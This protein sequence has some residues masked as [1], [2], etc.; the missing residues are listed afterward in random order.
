MVMKNINYSYR[1]TARL[2]QIIKVFLRH[3]FGGIIDK[4]KLSEYISILSKI[5]LFKQ[6]I[7]DKKL[8]LPERIRL[9]FEELGPTFV[10]LGQLLST[11]PDYVPAEYIQEF[12]KLQD[13]V[14]PFHHGEIEKIIKKEYGADVTTDKLFKSFNFKPI[15]AASIAQVHIATLHT[16]EEVAIKMQR[17]NIEKIIKQ[18]IRI[19]YKL[20]SI[21][22]NNLEE[23]KLFDPMGLVNEFEKTILK[24]LDFIAE[25]SSIDKF[26]ENF[27]N[28]KDIYIPKVYWDYTTHN[29]LVIERIHGIELDEIV[30]I[31]E[32]GHNP[33][34]VASI[35]LNCFCKQIME[36]GFFHADPHPGNSMVMADGRVALIDY[37]IT[38]YLDKDMMECLANIFIGYAEHDYDKLIETFFAMDILTDDKYLPLFKQ[39]LK[40]TSEPFYGRSL[41]HI[42]MREVFDKIIQICIKHNI[43]LPRNL[44]LLFKTFLQIESLGRK[45]D[46]E[47]SVLE[48]AKPYAKRLLEKGQDH[49]TILKKL[50]K[51]VTEMYSLIKIIPDNVNKVLVKLID[52][53]QRIELMHLGLDNIDTDLVRGINRITVGMIISASL[54]GSAWVI[55]AR[56]DILLINIVGIGKVSLTTL[57]GICGYNIATILGIW[58]VFSIIRSGKL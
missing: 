54:M 51:E 45:L 36:D 43:K 28:F 26:R 14:P 48:T 34:K 33:K 9:A 53:K 44:L 4:L 22:E 42:N 46:P 31:Q 5:E 52:G 56:S 30:K 47:V 50:K 10:K 16:G 17:P 2:R 38:G 32:A 55:S 19:L 41:K 7:D 1:N 6:D 21:L 27:K 11:R 35:G 23:S 57:L 18:D 24:E 15:A 3:G 20:A 49:H 39:D 25:A 58:L 8:T 37:G 29:I 13:N 40:E 12:K